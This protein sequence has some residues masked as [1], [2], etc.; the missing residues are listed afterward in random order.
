MWRGDNNQRPSLW[1]LPRAARVHFSEE[2]VDK[3][4][5]G[6]ENQVVHPPNL[7]WDVLFFRHPR[8]G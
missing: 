2:K 8:G 7:G 1:N 6:P 5:E 4:R 3:N